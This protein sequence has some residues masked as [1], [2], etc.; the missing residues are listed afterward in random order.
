MIDYRYYLYYKILN[1]FFAGLSV[2]SVFIIYVPL[3]PFVFS[4]GGVV[5]AFLGLF[6][7]KLYVKIIKFHYYVAINLTVEALMLLLITVFLLLGG[8]YVSALIVYVGYQIVF[9]F[10]GYVYRAETLMMRKT[11]LIR[12]TDI[13]KQKGYI[14]GMAVSFLFF[15]VMDETGFKKFTQVYELH[16]FLLVLQVLVVYVL[17]RAFFPHARNVKVFPVKIKT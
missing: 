12:L 8:G 6:I 15:F 16:F 10:G 3:E 9:A 2:G 17:V 7:A 5:L 1:S 4:A 14:A 11:T 13:A